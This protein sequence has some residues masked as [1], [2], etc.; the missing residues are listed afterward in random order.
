MNL[1][2]GGQI[3]KISVRITL[4]GDKLSNKYKINPHKD[5]NF[6]DKKD[7]QFKNK[8]TKIVKGKYY[9]TDES[10]EII[11]QDVTKLDEYIKEIYIYDPISEYK[12]EREDLEFLTNTPITDKI[13]I[14]NII[15]QKTQTPEIFIKS[16]ESLINSL[17]LFADNFISD[18][19]LIKLFSEW[20]PNTKET[21][22]YYFGKHHPEI[23]RKLKRKHNLPPHIFHNLKVLVSDKLKTAYESK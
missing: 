10:E 9:T 4:D 11:R 21:N 2:L 14:Y 13:L 19:N 7:K 3:H 5:N 12:Y 18:N 17:D 16:I 22:E 8:G 23:I 20:W 15:E 6:R 1:K